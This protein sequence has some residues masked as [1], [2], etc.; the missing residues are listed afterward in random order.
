M[1]MDIVW[2]LSSFIVQVITD[3]DFYMWK[4]KSKDA[5]N[6]QRSISLYWILKEEAVFFFSKKMSKI[7]KIDGNIKKYIQKRVKNMKDEILH[8]LN[9]R[10]S[11][12]GRVVNPISMRLQEGEKLVISLQVS[13]YLKKNFVIK[14]VYVKWYYII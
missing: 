1:V 12:I 3:C 10:C 14:N 5:W 6:G 11:E 2:I 9:Q 13:F 8:I 7:N 4:G